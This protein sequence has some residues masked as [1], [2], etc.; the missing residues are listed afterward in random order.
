MRTGRK[1]LTYLYVL[2]PLFFFGEVMEQIIK[3]TLFSV[4][5]LIHILVEILG[6]TKRAKSTANWIW[7]S[8][9]GECDGH[10][11]GDVTPCRPAEVQQ[12]FRVTYC[13][14]LQSQRENPARIQADAGSK[15]SCPSLAG[16]TD[17]TSQRTVLLASVICVCA[18]FSSTSNFDEERWLVL[19]WRVSHQ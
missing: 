19:R 13:L 14:L 3:S 15:R 10:I 9:S 7:G 17:L 12:R 11:L 4:S 5:I 6:I 1:K 2:L 8:I 18:R 16:Y